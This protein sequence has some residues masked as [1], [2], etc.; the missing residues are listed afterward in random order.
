MGKFKRVLVGYLEYVNSLKKL[1]KKTL[2]SNEQDKKDKIKFLKGLLKE[3][4]DL[5]D[6]AVW[7]STV[8]QYFKK[9]S[10]LKDRVKSFELGGIDE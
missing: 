6:K 2:M 8:K 3:L 4:E 1:I 10:F 7:E 5:E 9:T